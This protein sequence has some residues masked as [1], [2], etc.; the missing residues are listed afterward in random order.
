MR[1]VATASVASGTPLGRS[2]Y[3]DKG[4]VL[5]QEGV[6]LDE[7]LLNRLLDKGI[8]FLY[9]QDK[10]TMDIRYKETISQQVH[11]EAIETI[12][13]T[14]Q[15]VQEDSYISNSFVIE[16]AT[17]RFT[18][19]IRNLSV[20]IKN[21]QELLELLSDVYIYDNYIFTHSLNVTMYSLAIGMQLNLTQKELEVLGLG[22]I[23]HDV[24]KMK[25]PENI[26]LKPGRLTQEEYEEV[27]KHAE[28]G[29]QMLRNVQTM[30]L[31]VA[32]CAFQHHE[33]VNGTGYPRG[34][35]G[36]EIHD[37]GKIIAVADVFDAVTSNRV[38]RT[39]MLP[40][41]G[42]EILYAGSDNLFDIKIIEAF[43]KAVAIYPVG[44]TVLLNDGR[45]GVV[46]RQNSGLSERPVVRV[47][48]E[49][50]MEVDPYNLDLGL[51]LSIVIT[52]CD[53]TFKNE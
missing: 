40:H 46:C 19:L 28:E 51:E 47:L 14:F 24:G 1:L 37:Y 22:A 3:N 49:N 38:Y 30:P 27:K 4:Q 32:H 11:R 5:L 44:I 12:E 34:I 10:K 25:I 7:N 8:D 9:I 15:Q 43:R 42:L 53:T 45:K 31:L 48:E 16:K 36:K 29:F 17:K 39:A 20:E 18:S 23:L 41:E 2:I 6:K 52:G 50:G 35:E 26:L 13:T 21:N 33:R